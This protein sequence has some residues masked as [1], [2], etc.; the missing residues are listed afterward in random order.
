MKNYKTLLKIANILC[1][2]ACIIEFIYID[3]GFSYTLNYLFTVRDFDS[4]VLQISSYIVFY[5]IMILCFII[6]NSILILLSYKKLK[7]DRLKFLENQNLYIWLIILTGALMILSSLITK[8]I[9]IVS[10]IFLVLGLYNANKKM[11]IDEKAKKSY[12]E[13]IAIIDSLYKSNYI[14][15]SKMIK[16]K[17]DVYSKYYLN[18][19]NNLKDTNT[20][21]TDSNLK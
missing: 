21:T 16:L 10:F 15:E 5:Y 7:L 8:L 4:V 9:F 13:E 3:Y 19:E 17:D 2:I 20:N 12:N 18:K 1:I 6:A 14:N 11:T